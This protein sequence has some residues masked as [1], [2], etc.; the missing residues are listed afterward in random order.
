MGLSQEAALSYILATGSTQPSLRNLEPGGVRG[1]EGH[2]VTAG[3]YLWLVEKPSKCRDA[4][5]SIRGG[6]DLVSATCF[7]MTQM[8]SGLRIR[9]QWLWSLW[10][11]KGL[12][13]RGA[14][15]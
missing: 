15:G 10:G 2:Q 13:S 11:G 12:I 5:W 1:R 6:K 3:H 9:L 14:V 8:C 4:F 7:K